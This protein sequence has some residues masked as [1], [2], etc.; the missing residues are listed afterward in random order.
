M[1]SGYFG[2]LAT[3]FLFGA[4]EAGAYPNATGSIRRWFPPAE[5]AS[6][7]G[8]VWGA[9]RIGGA[10]TPV[11]V[12]PLLLAFGWRFV[13]YL[14]GA[15]GFAWAGLWWYWYRDHPVDH[16]S[17]TQ[18]ELHEI[19]SAEPTNGHNEVPWQQLAKSKQLWLVMVMYACYAWGST[20]YIAWLPEFLIKGRRLSEREMSVLAALPFVMGA[21]GNLL[22]GI[23]SDRWSRRFGPRIGR[24]A[25]GSVCLFVSSIL[26]ISTSLCQNPQLAVV[27]LSLGFGI[28]D[29]MLP[30]AWAICLDI[31]GKHAGAVSGAMNTAG[32]AGGFI[33]SVMFGYLV[34]WYGSYDVP[35]FVI[36]TMVFVS[37]VLF[38]Q[39]DPTR[40][41]EFDSR[42]QIFEDSKCV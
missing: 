1:T 6:A 30:C 9:S 7:Q 33:C 2:L 27:L 21:G 26:L 34:G 22:G 11:V 3:R 13:F 16:A 8:I 10:L 28:M 14:F 5:R 25:L 42:L 18:A 19:G 31:G 20:F 15:F 29:C 37:A 17:V 41:I 36:A 24:V 12:V 32:Q 39:I 38:T 40:Q 23:L 4:G 35:L